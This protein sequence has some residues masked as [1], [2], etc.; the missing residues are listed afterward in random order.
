MFLILSLSKDARPKC[1]PHAIATA[2][3]VGKSWEECHAG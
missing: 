1:S 2:P 3:T